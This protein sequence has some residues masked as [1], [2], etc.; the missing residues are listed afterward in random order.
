MII[1][2]SF[3]LFKIVPY[4]LIENV[5]SLSNFCKQQTAT[6]LGGGLLCALRHL[7]EN[8]GGMPQRYVRDYYSYDITSYP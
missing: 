5:H 2:I 7:T 8:S 4:I 3:G 6:Q 1:R